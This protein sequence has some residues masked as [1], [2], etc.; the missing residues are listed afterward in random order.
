MPKL[1]EIFKSIITDSGR[2][3]TWVITR[4]NSIN[5]NVNMTKNKLCSALNGKRKIMGDEFIALCKALKINP[6][7]IAEM[8]IGTKERK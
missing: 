3:Q 7:S 4:V 1:H 5:P 2:T 8:V 6:D